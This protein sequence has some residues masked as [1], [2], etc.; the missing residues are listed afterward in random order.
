MNQKWPYPGRRNHFFMQLTT[1]ILFM[2]EQKQ[3][4]FLYSYSC[5]LIN[6][7]FLA[8]MC[9]YIRNLTARQLILSITTLLM[10]SMAL[11]LAVI[12]NL[13]LELWN[14][15]RLGASTCS[16]VIYEIY[17][18]EN[19][20]IN[21]DIYTSIIIWYNKGFMYQMCLLH[22]MFEFKVIYLVQICK[23]WSNT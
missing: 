22:S 7:S 16:S 5:A 19:G 3:F 11:I 10:S 18:G 23:T 2:H 13:N 15:S 12:I 1:K 4:I 6:E 9:I 14:R 21:P 17:T 20:I 8:P